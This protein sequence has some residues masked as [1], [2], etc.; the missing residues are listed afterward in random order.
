[1]EKH[2]GYYITDVPQDLKVVTELLTFL[3]CDFNSG[4]PKDFLHGNFT[5]I[6]D[7]PSKDDGYWSWN[8]EAHQHLVS[9]CKEV[10]YQAFVRTVMHKPNLNQI[11]SEY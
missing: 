2:R 4:S 6:I 10:S 3:K 9:I 7:D 8:I 11:Y 1:M 5:H